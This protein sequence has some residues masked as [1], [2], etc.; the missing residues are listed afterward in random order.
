MELAEAMVL[1]L[2]FLGA[3]ALVLL[4]VLLWRAIQVMEKVERLTDD[5][6]QKSQKLDGFFDLAEKFEIL[7]DRMINAIVNG[8]MKLFDR[9]KR[10]DDDE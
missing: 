2:Y 10:G 6:N 9:R 1:I 7:N 8:V 3:V 5:F 4:S